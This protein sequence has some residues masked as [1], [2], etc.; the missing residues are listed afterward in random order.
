MATTAIFKFKLNQQK[1]ILWYNKVTIFM[2]I[3]LY[4]GIIITL[5]I[6]PLSTLSKLFDLNNDQNFKNIWVFCL[7]VCG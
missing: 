2:I 1:I 5:S 4:L 6:L 7:A 3:S